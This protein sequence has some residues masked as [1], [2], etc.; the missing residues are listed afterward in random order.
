MISRHLVIITA[1]I[2]I[3]HFPGWSRPVILSV[4]VK[5]IKRASLRLL[6]TLQR[7][8]HAIAGSIRPSGCQFHLIRQLMWNH[9]IQL[10]PVIVTCRKAS[11]V[12][13]LIE[14]PIRPWKC[15]SYPTGRTSAFLASQELH[16]I[17]TSL[18][19]RHFFLP[20]RRTGQEGITVFIIQQVLHPFI[21]PLYRE[22]IRT[23]QIIIETSG[24][25]IA[26]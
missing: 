9:D 18:A 15:I 4:W 10:M 22:T 23:H 7:Q 20:S 12:I 25:L 14:T 17:R 19:N 21:I 5:G 3:H 13:D 16:A 24:D 11:P 2:Q 1:C 8:G 6:V 26:D